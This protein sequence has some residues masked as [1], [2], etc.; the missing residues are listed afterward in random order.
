MKVAVLGAGAIGAYVGAALHR[1]GADTH[2]VARGP[3]LAA[4]RRDGVRVLSPSG[5]FTARAHATDDP[6]EIGPV[7]FVFL[8]LKATSYAACGPL[9]EPLLHSTTAVI[10]AQNGIPWW[11][12]HRHG[13]PH[14]GRRVES[15]D[16]GGAVSAVLAPERAVGCVVYAAT[17]LEGPGVV[18]HLEGTRFSVGEPDRTISARCRAFSEAMVAGGLKCPVEPDL[19]GDIW[20]K[21]LGNISFNPIS[22]LARATMRQMCLHGGTRKVIETMMAETMSVARALGCEVG[23]SIERRMAGAERVGDH[24]TSTLQDLERGKP[25]ELDVLLAAVVELAAVTDVEVPTLRTVHAI[26]DLLALRSAA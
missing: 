25:L 17:E 26:S 20:I 4:M 6:A 14:D 22:A 24:R 19:R 15:V 7:D 13:G 9:I 1:A 16:P 5:E 10:A 11:Y 21:L 12:F 23:V 18:R 2:L 3:H 8:G